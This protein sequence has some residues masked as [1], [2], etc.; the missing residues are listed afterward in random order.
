MKNLDIRWKQRFYNFKKAFSQFER[1]VTLALT[2]DLSELEGQGLIK[3]FEFTHELA[4]KM[5]KD[6]LESRGNKDIYGSKDAVRESFRLGLV[7]NGELWMEM[8]EN[9]NQTVHT[10]NLEIAKKIVNAIVHKYYDQFDLLK[11]KFTEFEKS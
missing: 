9:R 4:W 8:I 10:Y 1:G 3:A 11:K 5:L 6:F 2:K 7:D